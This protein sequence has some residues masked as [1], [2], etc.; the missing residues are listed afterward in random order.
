MKK[1][2]NLNT[3]VEVTFKDGSKKIFSS[4]KEAADNTGLSEAALKIRANKSRAGSANKKDK[5]HVRWISDT[6]FRSYQ[7]KKSKNKG[8]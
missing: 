6:T 4:L 1:S 5:I 2:Q 8:N 7:A 3:S